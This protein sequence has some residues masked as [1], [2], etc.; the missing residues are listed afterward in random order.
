MKRRFLFLP[1]SLLTA[2]LIACTVTSNVGDL[3][4][5]GAES[6]IPEGGSDDALEGS[7]LDAP[8]DGDGPPVTPVD[9][10]CGVTFAQEATAIDIQVRV[11]VEPDQ[12]GGDVLAGTYVLT[13]MDAYHGDTGS[14]RVRETMEVRGASPSGTLYRLIEI[15]AASG[16]FVNVPLHGETSLYT[17]EITTAFQVTPQCPKKGF[18]GGGRYT[19]SGDTLVIYESTPGIVRTYHRVR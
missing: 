15:T 6:G 1:C 14:A 16:T 18:A 12:S 13:A 3:P 5:T 4:R 8:L 10:G 2:G 9:A 17:A 11:G 19:A 7:V